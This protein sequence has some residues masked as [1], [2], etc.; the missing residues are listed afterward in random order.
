MFSI[1]LK[2]DSIFI[3]SFT[4]KFHFQFVFVFKPEVFVI[5]YKLTLQ[6]ADITA[7]TLVP[8]RL[9]TWKNRQMTWIWR[10]RTWPSTRN[11]TFWQWRCIWS[12]HC[13]PGRSH[14]KSAPSIC[15]W[16]DWYIASLVGQA[17]LSADL[18]PPEIFDGPTYKPE[19]P[20]LIVYP[21]PLV[22]GSI[23]TSH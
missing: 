2:N 19:K 9:S 6:G 4:H 15:F 12:T 3:P 14:N 7:Y 8:I 20:R 16:R 23:G 1:Y 10:K 18:T 21:Q 22:F 13:F 11:E 17:I 5:R